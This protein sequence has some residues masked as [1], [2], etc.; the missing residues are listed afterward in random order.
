MQDLVELRNFHQ[1]HTEQSPLV[2]CTL[3]RKSGS[4]YRDV[5]AKKIVARDSSCGLLSGGC[6]EASIEKMARERQQET[7]FI[8]SFSTLSDEDRLMGYQTGCQGVIDILFENMGSQ[9]LDLL[10]P[11]GSP[12]K[13]MGVS[14][15][16]AGPQ[17]GDR[18]FCDKKKSTDEVLFE[19]W[20]QPVHLVIVGCGV[21]ADAY[22]PLAKGLG[23]SIQFLDYRRD[24]VSAERFP[25]EKIE[26]VP[27]NKMASSIPQGSH[28]A[29]VLMT[30]NYEVDLEIMRGLKDHH[31]GYL[32]C[33]GPA[34]RYRRLQQDLLK[35]YN[36]KVSLHL[37]AVVSAPAGLFSHSRSPNEIALSVVAQVQERLVESVSARTWT[38]ILAAG[39]SSRY[40]GPK[41]LASWQGQSLLSRAQQTARKLSGDKV[42]IVTGGHAEALSA[43][44]GTAH[45]IYNE[46]WQSGMG[47]SIAAGVAA[48]R[49]LD[50]KAEAIVILPV[51]QPL[52]QS[53]H[54]HLLAQ[55]CRDSQ[56]AVLTANAEGVVGSPAALPKSLF[57]RTQELR[58]DRGMKSVLK[59][60]EM[61]YVENSAALRD[62]DSPEELK[63][64]EKELNP[65]S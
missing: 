8:A 39:A 2:L 34:V 4:S 64:L 62:V 52:V 60:S 35:L 10:I 20:I 18:E 15:V 38:L 32:G 22:L 28:T 55:E 53:E 58:G 51:D 46:Q 43:H 50:P 29:V 44:L 1:K 42:M 24:R 17:L 11:F 3:I 30:H 31:V 54:L 7:P 12:A 47:T 23:W 5:G 19:P 33:L 13:A 27:I 59:I 9:D 37:D 61:I 36:E 49:D 63:N 41:A 56:R 57:S 48:I 25:G 45:F 6:L 40:G 65:Q 16:I 21:D 26:L 14:V